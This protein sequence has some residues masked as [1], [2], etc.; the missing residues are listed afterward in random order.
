MDRVVHPKCRVLIGSVAGG[1]AERGAED[2]RSPGIRRR[3]LI[4]RHLRPAQSDAAEGLEHTEG[5]VGRCIFATQADLAELGTDE[6]HD[7]SAVEEAAER[8]RRVACPAGVWQEVRLEQEAGAQAVAQVFGARDAPA[9]RDGA[10]RR[11]RSD[12]TGGPV[13]DAAQRKVDSSVEVDVRLGASSARHRDRRERGGLLN[14]HRN[15]SCL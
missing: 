11:Q 13:V 5:V 14:L 10:A 9:T 8:G 1:R 6:R 7:R 12:R 2:R 15:V 3:G 4:E